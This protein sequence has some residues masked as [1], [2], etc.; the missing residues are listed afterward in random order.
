MLAPKSHGQFKFHASDLLIEGWNSV[1]L[2]NHRLKT[3]NQP[4]RKPHS[5]LSNPAFISKHPSMEF[6]A[7]L[8][9][10][11]I[12]LNCPKQCGF[13]VNN[14]DNVWRF[15]SVWRLKNLFSQGWNGKWDGISCFCRNYT[16]ETKYIQI[17]FRGSLFSR[18]KH[19]W[20]C[21]VSVLFGMSQTNAIVLSKLAIWNLSTNMLFKWSET[22]ID[23]P[24]FQ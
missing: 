3:L 15:K 13:V 1:K 4:I 23:R 2:F 12:Y 10:L 18:W 24:F 14:I 20:Y 22:R 21:I 8:I 19:L 9:A 11:K 6:C 5:M 7:L 17:I 16:T